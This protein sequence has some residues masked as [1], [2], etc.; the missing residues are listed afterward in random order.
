M[1]ENEKYRGDTHLFRE[2]RIQVNL[3]ICAEI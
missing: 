1:A 3:L 2:M